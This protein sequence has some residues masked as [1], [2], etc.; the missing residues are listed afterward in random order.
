[1]RRRKLPKPLLAMYKRLDLESQRGAD[2]VD[3]VAVQ[4]LEN[5][6]LSRV[7]ESAEITGSML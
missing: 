1:M 7:V 5:G 6:R 2:R 4:P 3:I